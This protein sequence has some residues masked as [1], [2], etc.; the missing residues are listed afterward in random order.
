[1]T[2]I[3]RAAITGDLSLNDIA[4]QQPRALEVFDRLGLDSCCGG[5]KALSVVC[6]KHNLNLHEVLRDLRALPTR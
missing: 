1:M 3:P 2:T 6:E 4:A 5:A